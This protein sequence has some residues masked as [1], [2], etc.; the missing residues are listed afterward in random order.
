[1]RRVEITP[2]QQFGVFTVIREASRSGEKRMVHCRCS[3][4]NT[5]IV[6]LGSLR[7]G[8]TQ[9]CGECGYL[10]YKGKKKSVSA[11]SKE[12]KINESTLRSRLKNM[13]LKEALEKK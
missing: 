8:H 3:C 6:R 1:M 2:G 7:S 10:S 5:R 13:S 4:G 12:H 9:S 11:W